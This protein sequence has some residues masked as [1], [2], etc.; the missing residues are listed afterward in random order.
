MSVTALP[1]TVVEL[2]YGSTWLLTPKGEKADS[3]LLDDMM[4]RLPAIEAKAAGDTL[5][6]DVAGGTFDIASRGQHRADAGALQ[7]SVEGLV[8]RPPAD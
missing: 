7:V 8:N 2:S 4:R 3:G 1:P 5:H 6:R